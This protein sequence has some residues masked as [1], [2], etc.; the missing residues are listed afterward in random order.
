[1]KQRKDQSEDVMKTFTTFSGRTE[2]SDHNWFVVCLFMFI[3]FFF[4][5]GFCTLVNLLNIGIRL[6]NGEVK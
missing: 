5:F 2:M 6:Y 1:M 3:L 4:I